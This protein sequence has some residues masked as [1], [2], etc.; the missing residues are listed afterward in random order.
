MACGGKVIFEEPGSGGGGASSSS[1]GG[2]T[3]HASTGSAAVCL[4]TVTVGTGDFGPSPVSGTKCFPWTSGACPSLYA[5]NAYISVD[6]CYVLASVDDTCTAPKPGTCCYDI[7][8]KITCK[9]N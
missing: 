5:A 8:E 3:A 4:S 9:A 7:T 1:H 2:T 6:P